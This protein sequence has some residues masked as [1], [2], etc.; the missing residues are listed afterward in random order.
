MKQDDAYRSEHWLSWAL[1]VSAILLGVIGALEAFALINIGDA[2]GQAG[3]TA[4]ASGDVDPFQDGALFL[5]PALVMGFLAFSLHRGEHHLA[6]WSGPVAA[7]PGTMGDD[8]DERRQE[9]GLWTGEHTGAY[10]A[11]FAAIALALIGMLVGFNVI[12]DNH[13]FYDGM[14]WQLLAVLSSFLAGM[15]HSV[16][17]H[18]PAYEPDEVRVRLEDRVVTGEDR[19]TSRSQPGTQRR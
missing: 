10:V 2:I 12:D 6:R 7:R 14:T 15:L 13:S 9:E 11:T 3:E 19:S 18:Q 5:V 17:H 4:S 1:A 16:T 8:R